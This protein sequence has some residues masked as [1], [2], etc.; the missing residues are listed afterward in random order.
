MIQPNKILRQLFLR[1]APV[2]ALTLDEAPGSYVDGYAWYTA[3][4]IDI[5]RKRPEGALVNID[6]RC[7]SC[8]ASAT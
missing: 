3:R 5:G 7:N 4:I 6:K 2:R 1:E 8:T